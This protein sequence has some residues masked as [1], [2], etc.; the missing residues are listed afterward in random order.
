MNHSKYVLFLAS[1]LFTF[2]ATASPVW[3]ANSKWDNLRT[4]KPGLLIRVELNG[5]KSYEG[6]FQ[7]LNDAGITLRRAAGE[8][9]L[10]RKDVLRVYS[11]SKNHRVRN[12]AIGAA[13]G[14]MLATPI[15]LA[16]DLRNGWWHSTV[17]VW[18]VFVGPGAGIGAAIP[19]GGWHE[20]YHARGH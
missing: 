13:I 5:D 17:W 15:V 12:I 6:A 18:P 9:T 8:Q 19:T 2:A 3:A 11:R 4:L 14:V 16:N 20:V 10:A 7:A 1:I